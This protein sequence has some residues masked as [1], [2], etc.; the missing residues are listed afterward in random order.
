MSFCIILAERKYHSAQPDIKSLSKVLKI[1]TLRKGSMHRGHGT[2]Q[3][4]GY[5]VFFEA[6]GYMF[7]SHE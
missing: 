6:S 4:R 5:V 2:V 7:M 3:R 1:P